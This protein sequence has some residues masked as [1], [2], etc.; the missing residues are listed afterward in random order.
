MTFLVVVVR[1]N[2]GDG[3]VEVSRCGAVVHHKST[4]TGKTTD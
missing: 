3:D 4:M 2:S 1:S